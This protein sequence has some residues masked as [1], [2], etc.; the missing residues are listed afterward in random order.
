M[1]TQIEKTR[2]KCRYRLKAKQNQLLHQV[3]F[4]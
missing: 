3:L 1:S 2:G 4:R